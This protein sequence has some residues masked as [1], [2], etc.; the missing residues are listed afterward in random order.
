MSSPSSRTSESLIDC[1]VIRL[2]VIGDFHEPYGVTIR[3]PTVL[4]SA[5]A[6]IFVLVI[7]RCSHSLTQVDVIVTRA[8]SRWQH[9]D[10]APAT[11]H[12]TLPNLCFSL[13]DAHMRLERGWPT[14]QATGRELGVSKNILYYSR[15]YLGRFRAIRSPARHRFASQLQPQDDG[16]NSDSNEKWR[17]VVGVTLCLCRG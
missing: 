2:E 12:G 7:G 16:T 5:R 10:L 14:R 11:D 8:R 17:R 15:R 3:E 4:C 1:R 9:N 6:L 13:D